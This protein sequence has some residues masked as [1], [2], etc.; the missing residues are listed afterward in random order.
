MSYKNEPRKQKPPGLIYINSKSI[1]INVIRH[2]KLVLLECHV[3]CSAI[4]STHIG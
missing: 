1:G 3:I 2:L 4:S